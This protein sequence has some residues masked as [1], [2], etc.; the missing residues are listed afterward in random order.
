MG[1]PAFARATNEYE[2]SDTREVAFFVSMESMDF[3]VKA[4]WHEKFLHRNV[5][6]LWQTLGVCSCQLLSLHAEVRPGVP[7]MFHRHS[8]EQRSLEGDSMSGH[9]HC[10]CCMSC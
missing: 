1:C 9:G 6:A 4:S 7:P 5:D 10:L 3:S 2:G 8:P